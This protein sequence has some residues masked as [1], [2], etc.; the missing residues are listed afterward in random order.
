MSYK[1]VTPEVTAEE[2]DAMFESW[3]KTSSHS[4]DLQH[5]SLSKQRYRA[6]N[7]E[8]VSIEL[9]KELTKKEHKNSPEANRM[10][11][12]IRQA[13]GIHSEN[14]V[15]LIPMEGVTVGERVEYAV[16]Y[17]KLPQAAVAL[18]AD[19]SI[20][21]VIQIKMNK[22][23]YTNRKPL[24]NLYSIAEALN[25][26]LIWLITGILPEEQ[27]KKYRLDKDQDCE[28]LLQILQ[29]KDVDKQEETHITVQVM[30]NSTN[31]QQKTQ[32]NTN[33]VINNNYYQ[34]AEVE[35]QH[36]ENATPIAAINVVEQSDDMLPM[37]NFEDIGYPMLDEIVPNVF[38]RMEFSDY[39]MIHSLQRRKTENLY[40][41]TVN[42]DASVP[43]IN[44]GDIAVIDSKQNQFMIDGFYAFLYNN[45]FW[46]ATVTIEADGS[47]SVIKHRRKETFTVQEVSQKFKILGRAIK[48]IKMDIQSL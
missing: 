12:K 44:K 27:P 24:S 41:I 11:Q 25:V 32:N 20:G 34:T 16:K 10:R 30:E 18:L 19:M 15:P 22:T 46:I 45:Q 1:S 39:G 43:D 36:K 38:K 42:N 14:S 9:V 4:N 29:S 7:I 5:T 48:L 35:P 26:D 21:T 40:L 33:S 28:E 8:G 6:P 37:F 47:I 31:S 13:Y 23:N 2:V 17:Y 3:G